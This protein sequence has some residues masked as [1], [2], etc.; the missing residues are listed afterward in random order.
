[1]SN[2]KSKRG[3]NPEGRDLDQPTLSDEYD[4]RKMGKPLKPKRK[5]T[6][7]KT[8]EQLDN[9]EGY[10]KDKKDIFEYPEDKNMTIETALSLPLPLIQIGKPFPL[11]LRKPRRR[12]KNRHYT[13]TNYIYFVPQVYIFCQHLSCRL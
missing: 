6:R 1:M 13:A 10:T 12:R 5:K 9:N 4:L 8:V 7:T 3:R 11:H 2:K